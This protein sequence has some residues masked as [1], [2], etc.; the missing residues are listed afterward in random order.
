MLERDGERLSDGVLGAIARGVE[1]E[2][3]GVGVKDR[4]GVEEYERDGVEN[5][6]DG[7]EE[8]DRDGLDEKDR[9]GE[10]KD[11]EV[12]RG[13]EKDRDDIEG[14]AAEKL[15]P[16][17]PIELRGIDRTE[18]RRV[19]A[20]TSSAPAKARVVRATIHA[21]EHFTVMCLI[22]I[23]SPRRHRAEKFHLR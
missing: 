20:S 4:D 10:E 21:S 16:P 5:D 13:A 2:E 15:R 19:A 14:R 17:E 7:V 22:R 1:L 12:E 23:S 11:R 9:D 3:R 8:K 6:R 18:L